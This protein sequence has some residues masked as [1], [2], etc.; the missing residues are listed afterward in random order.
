MGATLFISI[1]IPAYQRTAYLKRLLDSIE[2]Q[3]YRHFEVVITDDSPGAEIR[4]LIENHPVMPMI[5]YVKNQ[6]TLGTPENWN[7]CIRAARADWIKVMHDDDW[8]SGP[9][10]LRI[11]ADSIFKNKALLY[12]SAY[13]NVF[14]DA[15]LDSISPKPSQLNL[16]ERLPESLFASNRIGPPSV[17]IFK[18][19]DTVLFDH[20]MKWLVDID[21]YIRY[22]KKHG[23]PEYISK[24][25][26]HIGISETQVTK[27]SF[28]MPEIEIPERF[29]LG[30]KLDESSIK[31]IVIFDAWW[32][33]LRNLRI[34]NIG[35]IRQ[36]GYNGNI[37]VI[38]QKMILYQAGI[39]ES[40][41]NL[42]PFSKVFMF[43]FYLRNRKKLN[44]HNSASRQRTT[45]NS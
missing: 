11:F 8:F 41:L 25:L 44:I 20:R 19:D 32:R 21:F 4:D 15:R 29:L 40:L 14:Q 30:E 24:E 12:F 16:I 7:E 17:V 5:R 31:H 33:F 18:K 34:R 39:P 36:S 28:G 6:R 26:V 35:Q 45:G 10:S 2:I 9:E 38:I 27:V 43:S 22:I 1:C 37:P 3:T 42:G 23:R 13:S